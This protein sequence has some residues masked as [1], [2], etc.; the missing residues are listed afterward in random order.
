MPGYWLSLQNQRDLWTARQTAKE[1][2]RIKRM[3]EPVSIDRWRDTTY[4]G[5]S[6]FDTLIRL[7]SIRNSIAN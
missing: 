7:G 3:T 2:K 5:P 6:L 1:C 4:F